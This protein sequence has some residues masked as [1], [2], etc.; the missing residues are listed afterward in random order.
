M[1]EIH[2]FNDLI[3]HFG[4]LD[5]FI[6]NWYDAYIDEQFI[7][8]LGDEI[9]SDDLSAIFKDNDVLITNA[10]NFLKSNPQYISQIIDEFVI[11]TWQYQ[12][13]DALID[14]YSLALAD[15]FDEMEYYNNIIKI[16]DSNYIKNKVINTL[17][18]QALSYEA[19]GEQIFAQV[20]QDNNMDTIINDLYSWIIKIEPELIPNIK[21]I[22]VHDSI[23]YE[24]SAFDDSKQFALNPYMEDLYKQ[25]KNH[26]TSFYDLHPNYKDNESCLKVI[27]D[28][29]S[30]FNQNQLAT[31]YSKIRQYA[32]DYNSSGPHKNMSKQLVDIQDNDKI[33]VKDSYNLD[34]NPA[35]ADYLR[36]QPIVMKR[37]YDKDHNYKDYILIGRNGLSHWDV[38]RDNKEIF[39]DEE[40]IDSNYRDKITFAYMLGNVAFVN[41]STIGNFG[42]LSEIVSALKAQPEI[43]KVYTCPNGR[44]GPITRLA[45]RV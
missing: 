43:R 5:K 19:R 37:K 40:N 10:E 34:F 8:I 25:L 1:E 30:Y 32:I 3:K 22:K 23:G 29:W 4:S 44:S 26:I 21:W 6:E 15:D 27:N 31:I 11:P 13:L 35:D 20:E 18:N 41:L 14:T 39:S 17:V 12:S 45:K 16:F 28:L 24:F 9:T 36:D 33:G 38:I 7:T 42:S 2:N